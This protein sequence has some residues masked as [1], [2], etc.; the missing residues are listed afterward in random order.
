MRVSRITETD[1]RRWASW[2]LGAVAVV[3]GVLALAK[4]VSLPRG[5]ARGRDLVDLATAGDALDP[6]GLQRHL[7]DAKAVADALKKKN[8]FTLTPPR[9]HPVKQVEGILGNEVL[10]SGKWYQV[11]QK[12]KDAKIVAIRPTE[13]EI[14]WDGKG[15]TFSPIA[16]ASAA[17]GPSRPGPGTPEKVEAPT[18]PRPAAPARAVAAEVP[19]APAAQD[20]LAWMGVELP[21]E[22][23][24]KML[25]R[26]NGMS[27]EEKEKA[28]QK[29]SEMSEEQKRRAVESF[30]AGN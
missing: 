5:T 11:G 16:A 6:N 13:V 25:E 29:W 17:P 23:K 26:W 2:A 10:I 7:A 15:K 1:R 24:N 9:E 30:G 4:V 22:V 20:D 21:P 14:E 8:P 19:A 18:G 27:D 28:K 12:I 3:L